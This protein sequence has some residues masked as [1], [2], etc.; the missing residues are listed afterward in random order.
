MALPW[1]GEAGPVHRGILDEGERDEDG[2][3][4]GRRQSNLQQQLQ[5]EITEVAGGE[6]ARAQAGGGEPSRAG[7]RI[8]E[9]RAAQDQGRVAQE[10]AVA[11]EEDGHARQQERQGAGGDGP[12]RLE[13]E[14]D[15]G[16]EE[17]RLPA[18]EPTAR[19]DDGGA[20]DEHDQVGARQGVGHQ[21]DDP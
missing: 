3:G 13:E 8:A 16:R 11:R 21:V 7:E 9:Q 6:G 14:T 2:Q 17:D 19:R 5:R 15:A 4:D 20:G 18:L 10:D 12:P 1:R